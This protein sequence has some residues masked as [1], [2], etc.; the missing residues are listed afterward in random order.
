MRTYRRN[1]SCETALV[2]LVDHI[3]W[4]MKN[5]KVS[6]HIAIDLSSAFDTVHVDPFL[7]FGLGDKA[8]CWFDNY[9]RS[10]V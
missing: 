8:L 9:L 2:K 10:T 1:Y 6:P 3:L 5:K 7:K 4:N